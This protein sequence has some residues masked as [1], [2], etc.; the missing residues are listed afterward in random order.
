MLLFVLI[1][2]VYN[3]KLKKLHTNTS[4]KRKLFGNIDTDNVS[5]E[6]K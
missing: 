2:K 4:V 3:E 6:G 1:D 5:T